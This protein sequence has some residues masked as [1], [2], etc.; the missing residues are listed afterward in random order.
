MSFGWNGMEQEAKCGKLACE[1]ELA[2]V[3]EVR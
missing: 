1:E 2:L 3:E